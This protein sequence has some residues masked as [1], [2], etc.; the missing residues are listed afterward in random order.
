MPILLLLSLAGPAEASG[1][2]TP[3][4][5]VGVARRAQAAWRLSTEYRQTG[6]KV[7]LIKSLM[8]R[9]KD[10]L[11]ILVGHALKDCA[12]EGRFMKKIM[13]EALAAQA[14]KRGLAGPSTAFSSTYD[15]Q[16]GGILA[17]LNLDWTV[18]TAD[19]AYRVVL[20]RGA[21]VQI[22][23]GWTLVGWRTYYLYQG[24]QYVTPMPVANNQWTTVYDAGR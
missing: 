14:V 19:W 17:R 10:T 21:V 20:P 22:R 12:H 1:S 4:G 6:K 15:P 11:G 18:N 24:Q 16:F 2:R 23:G 3:A 9:A 7:H 8:V 13:P 5:L